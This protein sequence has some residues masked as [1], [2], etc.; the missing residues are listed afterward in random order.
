MVYA[1]YLEKLK[2]TFLP[3]FTKRS[4]VHLTAVPKPGKMYKT[5]HAFTYLLRGRRRAVRA[6]DLRVVRTGPV[7]CEV[8][9]RWVEASSV[10]LCRRWRQTFWT[11]LT[12]ATLIITMSKW[13]HC[14]F[15]NWRWLFLFSLAV[16]V[17]EQRKIA[18]LTEKCCYLN[19]QSKVH[20]QLR[21]CG[22]FYHS[23]IQNFFTIKMI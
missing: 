10:A 12:I 18:F 2:P 1:P 15:D 20:T 16:N 11:L 8:R 5:G 13:Q 23:C 4:S 3:W 22:K 17:N 6:S 19:L 9:H 14:K 7:C 21:W